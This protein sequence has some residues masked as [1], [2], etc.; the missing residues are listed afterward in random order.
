MAGFDRAVRRRSTLAALALALTAIV[1]FPSSASATTVSGVDSEVAFRSALSTLSGDATAGPH[2]IEITGSFSISDTGSGDPTYSGGEDLIIEGGGFTISSGAADLRF[3][4]ADCACNLTIRDLTVDGFSLTTG[5]F[6]YGAA[7]IANDGDVTIEGSVFS[8]NSIEAVDTGTDPTVTAAGAAIGMGAGTLTISD[9]IF[10][11]NSVKATGTG[12]K[13]SDEAAV[14]AYGGAVFVDSGDVYI[15]DDSLF[16]SNSA[17]G[18]V[19]AYY[20]NDLAVEGGAV[21]AGLGLIDVRTGATFKDNKAKGDLTYY[22][23][24]ADDSEGSIYGGALATATST[25]SIDTATFSGNS[26]I[27]VGAGPV[28]WLEYWGEGGAVYGEG[29]VSVGDSTFTNNKVHVDGPDAAASGGAI[30]SYGNGLGVF[31]GV[32]SFTGNSV[33]ANVQ[34]NND[35]S[36]AYGGAIAAFNKGVI[37]SG[38][39]FTSNTA[40]SNGGYQIEAY[41]GALYTK[42][43]ARTTAVNFTNNKVRGTGVG[44]AEGGGGAVYFDGGVGDFVFSDTEFDNN[45]VSLTST[46]GDSEVYGGAVTEW[47]DGAGDPVTFT[48]TT[49]VDNWAKAI[50]PKG[51]ALADGG[52]F[53]LWNLEGEVQLSTFSGNRALVDGKT[54]ASYGGAIYGQDQP[55]AVTSSTFTSNRAGEGA[56]V[57][58]DSG[59]L[60]TASSAYVDAKGGDG[61]VL[62]DLES[63]EYNF[64]NEGTC[65]YSYVPSHNDYGLGLDPKFEALGYYGGAT[66]TLMPKSTSPL[67]DADLNCPIAADQNTVSRPVGAECDSG[68]AEYLAAPSFGVATPKGTIQVVVYGSCG[69]SGDATATPVDG[70][71]S[72]SA[73]SDLI[74][75]FGAFGFTSCVPVDG[76]S[77]T[78]E[79]TL[80][81]PANSLW[82]VDADWSKV[83]GVTI[84]GKKIR[85]T[86]ADGGSLDTDGTFNGSVT[87]PVAPGI[88]LSFTG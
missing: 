72:P 70:S 86:L 88:T 51:D 27:G 79:L 36:E 83:P 24:D 13:T 47:G 76:G 57:Y 48:R 11:N 44:D 71:Y 12:N 56:H 75:P 31:V 19:D 14:S 4:D 63:L 82:K 66:Q 87:D 68:A 78:V 65:S 45:S 69:A 16:Q 30:T 20:V 62:G 77:V 40:T 5:T 26:V 2:V 85:Y 42:T 84:S 28:D 54:E 17:T 34:T 1:A 74:V 22:S 35:S 52:G 41:G 3:L 81:S 43:L 6:E 38:A 18:V 46:K 33:Y 58:M 37:A 64:D 50:A 15:S 53:E 9:S 49:F 25:V 23:T 67:V 29:N 10:T 8:H 7:V 39:T 61:C 32:S 80:P 55:I 21:F 60:S 73:P 59:T